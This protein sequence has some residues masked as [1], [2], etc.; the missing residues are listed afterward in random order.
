MPIIALALM[1]PALVGCSPTPEPT[2]TP[3][4][5]FA[6]EEE[7]FA[8]AE[9]TYRAYNEAGNTTGDGIDFLTG[10]ALEGE[11]ATT[12]YLQENG[13]TLEGASEIESFTGLEIDVGAANVVIQARVCVDVSNVVVLNRSGDDVTPIDRVDLLAL[14]VTFVRT[15]TELLIAKSEAVGD[16]TC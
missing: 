11:L 3:T 4:P 15:E 2:P 7:A 12:R 14:D 10:S 13:L 1:C 9:E 6:S 8:A 5:A 16:P